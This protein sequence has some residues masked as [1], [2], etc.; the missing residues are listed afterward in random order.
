MNL[1][2][3]NF[4]NDLPTSS[5]MEP[6]KESIIFQCKV[7][8]FPIIKSQSIEPF[9]PRYGAQVILKV[10]SAKKSGRQICLGR[11]NPFVVS[12]WSLHSND[13]TPETR[14][15]LKKTKLQDKKRVLLFNVGPVIF[16]IVSQNYHNCVTKLSK[17]T[18]LSQNYHNCVTKLSK[19]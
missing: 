15:S 9:L 7:M 1:M 10:A 13:P 16:V 4:F 3:L 2:L 18:K 6:Y 12:C 5:I 17:H 14:L 11:R 8:C 19:L